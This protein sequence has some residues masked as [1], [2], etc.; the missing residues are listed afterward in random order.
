MSKQIYHT[1][2]APA[3]IGPY[4]QCAA[5]NGFLYVSGCLGVDPKTGDFV[6]QNS[7]DQC[8][9]AM[10]NMKAIL[11]CAGSTLD[12]VIKCSLFVADMSE[13]AKLNAVY[14]EYFPERPPARECIQAACLPKNAR[15]EISCIAI[16]HTQ[17]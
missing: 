5:A 2:K 15:F 3:A 13:F 1:D 11:E 7:V 9:C 14:A 10:E 4:S 8:R 12:D 17:Q 16:H 6:A